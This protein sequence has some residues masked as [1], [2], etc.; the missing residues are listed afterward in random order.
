M[1]FTKGIKL[2]ISIVILENKRL[3]WQEK[4]YV[5]YRYMLRI[6]SCWPLRGTISGNVTL[7]TPTHIS[8]ALRVSSY[9]I[10][11]VILRQ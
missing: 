3:N 6:M 5:I 10:S 7:S 4:I 1:G 11:I 2:S 9:Q 8:R